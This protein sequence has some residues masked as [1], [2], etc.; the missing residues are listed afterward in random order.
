ME[1]EEDGVGVCA[2]KPVALSIYIGTNFPLSYI[3]KLLAFSLIKMSPCV[4]SLT[5]VLPIIVTMLFHLL[6]TPCE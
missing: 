5:Y 1:D 3:F 4:H 2:D 6:R